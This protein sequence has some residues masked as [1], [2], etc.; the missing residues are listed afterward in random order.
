MHLRACCCSASSVQPAANDATTH[1]QCNQW[2]TAGPWIVSATNGKC[3]CNASSV[4]PI[5]ND[6]AA[7]PCYI[8]LRCN[9]CKQLWH[10]SS[11]QP[12]ANDAAMHR[13]CNQQQTVQLHIPITCRCDA[14]VQSSRRLASCGCG[15]VRTSTSPKVCV[16]LHHTAD[17]RKC[18]AVAT[19]AT[20][21]MRHNPMQQSTTHTIQHNATTN[22]PCNA[23]Q[24][25]APTTNHAMQYIAM[26]LQQPM[27]C[28]TSQCGPM[29]SSAVQCW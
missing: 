22:N 5:A 20:H 23:I 28:N 1:C 15:W 8:Y 6:A 29:L 10:G 21:A 18:P 9:S 25:N 26:H 12:I 13:E 11:V 3:C 17:E 4:Q 24:C 2:H 19:N 14:F 27:Q 7:H 16:P